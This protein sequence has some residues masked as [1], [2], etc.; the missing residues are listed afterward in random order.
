MVRVVPAE[1]AAQQVA[2]VPP[3]EPAAAQGEP[4]VRVRVQVEVG[5]CRS[6]QALEVRAA[7]RSRDN[8]RPPGAAQCRA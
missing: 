1:P 4:E 8:Q 6:A 2:A 7:D 3:Q 5:G